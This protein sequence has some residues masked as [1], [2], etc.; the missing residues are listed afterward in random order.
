MYNQPN[1]ASRAPAVARLDL[2]SNAC[3]TESTAAFSMSLREGRVGEVPE[4]TAPVCF[5]GVAAAAPLAADSDFLYAGT[6][7]A[8]CEGKA[9]LV[10]P[11]TLLSP[12][13]ATTLG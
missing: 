11:P 4:A 2:S 6:R 7:A 5:P 9:S 3:A 10:L 12:G 13:G 8:M 1:R